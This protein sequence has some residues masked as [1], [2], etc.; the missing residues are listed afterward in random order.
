MFDTEMKLRL[1]HL[2]HIYRE[3]FMN[4]ISWDAIFLCTYPW[5][6]IILFFYYHLLSVLFFK[7]IFVSAPLLSF[8]STKEIQLKGKWEESF[9]CIVNVYGIPCGSCRPWF[10]SRSVLLVPA[11]TSQL[12]G[13]IMGALTFLFFF[14][15]VE[16]KKKKK[17]K[18]TLSFLLTFFRFFYCGVWLYFSQGTS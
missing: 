6:V 16:N 3:S 14:F 9:L 17:K 15:Y 2:P 4:M 10:V 8:I 13:Q 18:K 5:T 11:M 12:N 7:S 1:K